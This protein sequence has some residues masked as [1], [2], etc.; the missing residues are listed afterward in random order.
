MVERSMSVSPVSVDETYQVATT[1]H[2][3]PNQAVNISVA[4]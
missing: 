4:F 3:W 1:A 2:H